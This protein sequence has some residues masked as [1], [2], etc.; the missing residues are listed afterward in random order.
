MSKDI[1]QRLFPKDSSEYEQRL[2]NLYWYGQSVAFIGVRPHEAGE[3]IHRIDRD[4]FA[5]GISSIRISIHDTIASLESN[6]SF[7]EAIKTAA[8][9]ELDALYEQ[10]ENSIPHFCP[11]LPDDM[12]SF[13]NGLK[14]RCEAVSQQS[15]PGIILYVSEIEDVL[16]LPANERKKFLGLLLALC[17]GLNDYHM[18]CALFSRLPFA[19]I[20]YDNDLPFG[21]NLSARLLT[22]TSVVRRFCLDELTKM[23]PDLPNT[24]VEGIRATLLKRAEEA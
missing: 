2:E 11:V 8:I 21:M 13:R 10:L 20:E 1:I 24:A 18:V 3:L 16:L 15:D 14:E 5:D 6:G 17:D 23:M 19:I 9:K 4:R 7:L 12:M 22:T